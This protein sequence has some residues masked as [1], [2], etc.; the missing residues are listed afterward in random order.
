MSSSFSSTSSIPGFLARGALIGTLL[1]STTLGADAY[2]V[3]RCKVVINGIVQSVLLVEV[4]GEVKVHRLGEEGLTRRIAFN[5]GRA[6]D[7]A[8]AKYGASS[9]WTT[10]TS[11]EQAAN[12]QQAG[13]Y[14]REGE[15]GA[16]SGGGGGGGYMGN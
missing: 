13:R 10:G 14:A 7:W 16:G 12:W 8:A 9:A 11:C 2:T 4:G 15:A 6:L 3:T 5:P 1:V